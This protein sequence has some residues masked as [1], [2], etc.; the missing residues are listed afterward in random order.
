MRLSV[1]ADDPA[2]ATQFL[3][4]DLDKFDLVI[5]DEASQVPTCKAVGTIARARQ[6]I[7]VGDPKQLPPTTFFG[8]DFKDDGTS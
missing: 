7:V 6:V 3:D 5:F 2:S 1:Y 4:L 8:A